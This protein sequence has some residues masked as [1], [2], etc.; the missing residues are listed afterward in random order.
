MPAQGWY[1]W[2]GTGP[3]LVCAEEWCLEQR[4]RAKFCMHI[5]A[6]TLEL[7]QP[8]TSRV[9]WSMEGSF[10]RGHNPPPPAPGAPMLSCQSPRQS[11]PGEWDVPLTHWGQGSPDTSIAHPLLIPGGGGIWQVRNSEQQNVAQQDLYHI[12]PWYL[13]TR[14]TFF[15]LPNLCTFSLHYNPGHWESVLAKNDFTLNPDSQM[16]HRECHARSAHAVRSFGC[17]QILEP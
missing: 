4:K 13:R 17:R 7:A 14:A 1:P 16:I 2:W 11:H 5:H 3:E 9:L 12:L 15:P 6:Q 8:F 10:M